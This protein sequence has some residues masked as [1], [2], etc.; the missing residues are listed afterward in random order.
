M[1]LEKY[2]PE[3]AADLI[4][5]WI[6]RYDFKLKI[7]RS[8]STKYG[9][10]RP[11]LPGRNHQISVNNDLNRYSFLLTLVHEIAHL[12]ATEKYGYTSAPHGREWKHEFRILMQPFFAMG[13]FPD[14]VHRAVLNYLKNPAATSCSDLQ[15]QRVL[16]RYNKEVPPLHLEEMPE[17]AEFIYRNR[18]FT[19]G[20]CRRKRYECREKKSGKTYLFSPLT[21]VEEVSE[22]Q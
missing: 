16:H 15:L 14:D 19:K 6:Y 7:K 21:P 12:T 8:R 3:Q 4:A 20:A 18:R 2:I 9:D 5:R 13:I 1:I 17:G 11:R 10:Y 22:N